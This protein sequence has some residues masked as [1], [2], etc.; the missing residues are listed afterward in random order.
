MIRN[1]EAD[2]N[3][4][5][6]H[7]GLSPDDLDT[8]LSSNPVRILDLERMPSGRFAV[9]LVRPRS[10]TWSWWWWWW[11]WYGLKGS[12]VAE[13]ASPT[14]GRIVDV[15]QYTYG[16]Q[17]RYLVVMTGAV[18]KPSSTVAE[19]SLSEIY[20]VRIVLSTTSDWTDV[21]FVG[22]TIAIHAQDILEGAEANGL[23]VAAQS[24]IS[25]T[26]GCCDTVPVRVSFDAYLSRP[27]EWLQIEIE[28]GHIG[29]TTIS[30]YSPGESDPIDTYMHIGVAENPDPTNNRTFWIHSPYLTSIL[31]RVLANPLE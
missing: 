31:P 14:G 9:I 15:E 28:K 24:T 23:Q 22:G 13:V 16:G 12:D 7:S 6:W 11:W 1:T 8:I 27:A 2:A 29:Q 30:L 20:P 18:D 5:S 4:W 26:Q 19:A 10:E 3:S 25:I 21:R 17:P